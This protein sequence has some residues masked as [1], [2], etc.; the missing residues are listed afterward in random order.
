RPS[1]KAAVDEV[2]VACLTRP[3]SR[4]LLRCV[5][6]GSNVRQC[7]ATYAPRAEPRRAPAPPELLQP[8]F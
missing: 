5:E 3:F 2:T 8:E 4:A 1:V 7:F 6:E